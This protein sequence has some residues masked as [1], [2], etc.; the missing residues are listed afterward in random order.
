MAAHAMTC[1]GYL[2]ASGW[3]EASAVVAM[4]T[5]SPS[6]STR[7]TT[8]GTANQSAPSPN[9]SDTE[10]AITKAAAVATSVTTCTAMCRVSAGFRV[11]VNCV[12]AHQINQKMRTARPTPRASR[13]SA[14]TVVTCVT[15]KTNTRSKKSSTNAT[16]WPAG[17]CRERAGPDPSRFDGVATRA[18]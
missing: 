9:A 11:Q 7:T 6:P 3:P 18:S 1:R 5:W 2:G 17:A 12:H 14:V 4:R 15:A 8:Y 10:A 13:C 16:D